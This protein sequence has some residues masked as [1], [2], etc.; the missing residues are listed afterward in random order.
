MRFLLVAAL[1]ASLPGLLA[2]GDN[3]PPALVCSPTTPVYEYRERDDCFAALMFANRDTAGLVASEAEVARYFDR[4][5]R[6]VEAEPVLRAR[7]PQVK[8]VFAGAD[9]VTAAILTDNPNL[10]STW[11]MREDLRDPPVQPTGDPMFDAIVIELL[12]PREGPW[13]E[14]SPPGVFSL[15]LQ[16]SQYYNE[17]VLLVR[18]QEAS[19][20]LEEPGLQPRDDGRW[21]WLES[22]QG[23]TGTDADTAQIDFT[24]G[25]G[26][27]IGGCRWFHSVRAIVPA[28]GPV[29][30]YDMG[31]D[32]LPPEL[33][34]S[35]RTLSRP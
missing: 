32:S 6:A 27:C 1:L 30:V 34:L 15:I 17:D 35:P 13:S 11:M 26:D 18:L 9:Y 4:W 21:R 22:P 25:W 5:R 31:G 23:G 2:C 19:A 3:Q 10:I 33:A 16:T 24:F 28:V 12:E 8:R 7:S 20:W 29:V 14:R